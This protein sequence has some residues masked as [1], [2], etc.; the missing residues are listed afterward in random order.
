MK[1]IFATF[2]SSDLHRSLKRIENEAIGLGVYNNIFTFDEKNL[3]EKFFQKYKKYLKKGTRG[4]GYWCWKPQLILQVLEQVNNGDI[5]QYTDVGCHLNNNGIKRLN[6]YFDLAANARNGI[7]AFQAGI[8]GPELVFD[9]RSF[10]LYLDKEWTKGDLLDYLNVRYSEDIVNSPTI[11]SG[12]IF[13]RKCPEA[14][15]IIQEWLSVIDYDFSLLSDSP[16]KSANFPEFI[17]HRHDQAIFSI[18]CK[19]NGVTLIS[20]CEYWYPSSNFKKDDW[21]VLKNYPIHA[22]RDKDKGFWGNFIDFLKRGYNF[23]IRS[24]KKICA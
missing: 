20:A 22:V 24:V 1:K 18:L 4:F 15:K 14:I 5:I 11:G 2:A 3:E 13:I 12:I 21:A 23:F 6:D 10:P 7:L 17:E 19:K 16:S 9:N 8:P